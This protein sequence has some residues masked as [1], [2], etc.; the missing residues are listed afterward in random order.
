MESQLHDPDA[1]ITKTITSYLFYFKRKESA[2]DIHCSLSFFPVVCL[3]PEFPFFLFTYSFLPR[4]QR[5]TSSFI[6]SCCTP[7]FFFFFFLLLAQMSIR[8]C[9]YTCFFF[10]LFSSSAPSVYIFSSILWSFLFFASYQLI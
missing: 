10:F 1:F 8:L 9:C 5:A 3:F 4:N 6:L 2:V 7:S